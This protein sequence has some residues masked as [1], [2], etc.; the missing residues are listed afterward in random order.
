MRIIEK[1]FIEYIDLIELG[2][3]LTNNTRLKQIGPLIKR[4]ESRYKASNINSDRT[5]DIQIKQDL[6]SNNLQEVIYRMIG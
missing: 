3:P 2:Y 4:N 6:I 5:G 1:S